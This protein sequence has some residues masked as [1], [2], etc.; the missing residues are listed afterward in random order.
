M[1]TL[2]DIIRAN[3]DVVS[4]MNLSRGDVAAANYLFEMSN[5]IVNFESSEKYESMP[6]HTNSNYDES[7]AKIIEGNPRVVELVTRLYNKSN[8]T[9]I[10][11]IDAQMLYMMV[12]DYLK[13]NVKETEKGYSMQ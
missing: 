11:G 2:Y 3:P 9:F 13:G 12:N 8:G 5:S 10:G 7:I 6:V 1:E 4:G